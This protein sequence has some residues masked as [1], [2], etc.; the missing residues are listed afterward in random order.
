LVSEPEKAAEIFKAVQKLQE[1]RAYLNRGVRQT[2]R[3][4]RE[5]AKLV[6]ITVSNFARRTRPPPPASG[7]LSSA[8]RC[9]PPST[10]AAARRSCKI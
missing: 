10:S 1:F 8:T 9:S 3:K 4:R 5:L 6:A 7:R 2:F